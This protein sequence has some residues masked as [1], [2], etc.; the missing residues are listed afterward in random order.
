MPYSV[1]A[2]L[3]G[4]VLAVLCMGCGDNA[5]S[6]NGDVT[7]EGQPVQ[8]GRIDFL[9]ADGNGQ[10][11]SGAIVNGRY[12]INGVGPGPKIVQ[13]TAYPKA[14]AI[15]SVQELANAA[16]KG[17]PAAPITPL[18]PADAVG[19]NSTVEITLGAQTH[20]FKL[21]KKTAAGS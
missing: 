19:N 20:H 12:A 1:S 2:T 10:S 13:I 8:D 6:V 15:R 5:S 21:T 14:E 16:E 9:P 7:F 18:I 17:T 4:L 3:F 11:A